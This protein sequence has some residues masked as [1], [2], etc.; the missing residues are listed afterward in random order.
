MFAILNSLQ[1]FFIFLF[2]CVN[3]S[4]VRAQLARKKQT[5]ELTHGISLSSGPRYSSNQV[6][7]NTTSEEISNSN[8]ASR[9]SIRIS[10]DTGIQEEAESSD[11]NLM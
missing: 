1:G 8:I 11:G 10:L 2:Y 6:R 4:E 7:P 9:S 5:I 3:S